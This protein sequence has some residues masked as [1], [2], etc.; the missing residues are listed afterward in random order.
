MSNA[1]RSGRPQP[2][3]TGSRSEPEDDIFTIL[4]AAGAEEVE[5]P[6]YERDESVFSHCP[7]RAQNPDE[8]SER[9]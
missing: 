7:L 3:S 1:D 2:S 4:M 9:A 5:P 6:E 8:P